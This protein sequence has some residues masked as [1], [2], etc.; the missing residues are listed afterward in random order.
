MSGKRPFTDSNLLCQFRTNF[1]RR[2]RLMELLSE[3]TPGAPDT[4]DSPFCPRRQSHDARKATSFVSGTWRA[5][6]S[7]GVGCSIS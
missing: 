6:G 3:P 7:R 1:R 4:H 5:L 2:R